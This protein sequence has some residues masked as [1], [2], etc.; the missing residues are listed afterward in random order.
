MYLKVPMALVKSGQFKKSECMVMGFLNSW[1]EMYDELTVSNETI[2]EHTGLSYMTVST[3][4]KYLSKFTFIDVEYNQRGLT[5]YRKITVKNKAY[6]DGY[7]MVSSDW[8]TN[9]GMTSTQAIVLAYFYDKYL[10]NDKNPEFELPAHVICKE[11][12]VTQPLVYKTI[13]IAEAI[14]ALTIKHGQYRSTYTLDVDFFGLDTNDEEDVEE[15]YSKRT[16]LDLAK[17]VMTLSTEGI[18][19]AVD[20]FKKFMCMTKRWYTKADEFKGRLRSAFIDYVYAGI[21]EGYLDSD[22]DDE[23]A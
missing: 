19:K 13:Q 9:F 15:F 23:W 1:S 5:T 3:A 10:K 18:T 12:K 11:L 6:N 16:H 20:F 21:P 14:G 22:D 8:V 7:L 17:A 2:C 4:I